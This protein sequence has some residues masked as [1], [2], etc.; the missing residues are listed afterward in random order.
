M[1]GQGHLQSQ[2]SQH[3]ET[4][5]REAGGLLE[6]VGQRNRNSRLKAE[7]IPATTKY[8]EVSE[9]WPLSLLSDHTWAV[10]V[11]SA[12]GQ[13]SVHTCIHKKDLQVHTNLSSDQSLG[14]GLWRNSRNADVSLRVIAV[15]NLCIASYPL[16]YHTPG[17]P[18]SIPWI[19]YLCSQVSS[20]ISSWALSLLWIYRLA[21]L[22]SGTPMRMSGLLWYDNASI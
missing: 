9:G 10:H 16:I 21:L 11:C 19:G 14:Q 18:Q 5:N 1:Q 22:W 3:W 7:S 13:T 6:A 8:I 17:S 4:G 20:G 15:P 12:H 2:E